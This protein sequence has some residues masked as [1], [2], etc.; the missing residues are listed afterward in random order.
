[1]GRE[2]VTELLNLQRDGNKAKPYQAKQVRAIILKY[3]LAGDS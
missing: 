3:R 1:M 2:G